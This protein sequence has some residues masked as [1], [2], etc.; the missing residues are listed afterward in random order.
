MRGEKINA[1]GMTGLVSEERTKS[2]WG[3]WRRERSAHVPKWWLQKMHAG[4]MVIYLCLSSFECERV[5]FI[6]EGS[7]LLTRSSPGR[8]QGLSALELWASRAVGWRWRTTGRMRWWER[9]GDRDHVSMEPERK[10]R[11]HAVSEWIRIWDKWNGVHHSQVTRLF[12]KSLFKV[13]FFETWI[14]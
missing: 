4:G 14:N 6:C 3:Q 5:P 11:K 9:T 2:Q 10:E 13:F 1:T 12:W 8:C 7:S